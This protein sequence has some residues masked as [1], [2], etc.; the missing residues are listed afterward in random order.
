[1]VPMSIRVPMEHGYLFPHGFLF[2]GVEPVKDFDAKGK[3]DQARDKDTGERLWAVRGLDLDPDAGKYGRKAETV[4]KVTAPHQPV[5]PEPT[6]PGY[7]P[8]VEF[9]GITVTPYV[10]ANACNGRSSPHRCRAR[11]A[12]SIRATAMHPAGSLPTPAAARAQ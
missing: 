4:V 8:V 2:L 11:Q 9:D 6:M 3:D 10:D 1:M 5:P 7:P 12:W